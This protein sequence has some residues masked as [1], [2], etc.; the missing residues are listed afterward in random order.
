MS[1]LC[2]PEKPKRND[3]SVCLFMILSSCSSR[4]S[5]Y[6]NGVYF[7]SLVF[8][9]NGGSATIVHHQSR[10]MSSRSIRFSCYNNPA[11]S[12]RAKVYTVWSAVSI[13]YRMGNWSPWFPP[14]WIHFPSKRR[15][16][17]NGHSAKAKHLRIL[18]EYLYQKY[19]VRLLSF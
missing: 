14:I 17:K 12:Y 6:F 16:I 2:F 4:C 11:G 9:N 8:V 15:S 18:F 10:G 3:Q 1:L 5:S 19:W 13:K 7:A